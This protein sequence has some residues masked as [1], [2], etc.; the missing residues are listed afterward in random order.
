MTAELEIIL[1]YHKASKHNF[2]AYA[3]GPSRLNMSIKPD[4]FFNYHGTRHFN[5]EI[6][7]DEQIKAE[8][9]PTYE[10]V[11]LP[12]KLKP[13]ELNAESISKLFFDSFAIS[14]WKKANN[15]KWP[16]RA[17]PSSGNLHPTEVYLLSG[18]VKGLLKNPSVC[19]YAP[20]PHALEL[21]TE[22]PRETWELLSL[23]FPE[24]T[25]FVGLTSIFWR[26][27]WKYGLRAFR[28]SQHDIGHAIAALTFAAAGLGWKTSLLADMGSEEVAALLGISG[29][30][31]PE[32]QEPACLLA[33]CPADETCTK[34]RI[35]SIMVSTFKNLSWAGIPNSLSPEHVE[36]LGIE[37][38]ASA[39]QKRESDYFEKREESEKEI[40]SGTRAVSLLKASNSR[41]QL[42]PE[43]VPLRSI[44]R[45]RRS[46]IEMDNS[47]YMEKETFYA[48]L[49]RTLPE[50]NPIFNTLAFGSFTHLLLFVNRV[51]DLL[52][53]LYIFLRK[54]E[55]KE[56]FKA[57]IRPDFLWE[58]PK[59]CPSD[60]EF[61]LLLE[62]TLH[63][64]AAQL[65]CAQRKV[66]DACFTAC[67]LSEFEEPLN[68]FGAWIYPYLFW[69]CG[70]LGQL[71]YLEAEANGLRGC[72]IGC[73]F[74]DPLH[75]TIGLKGL[76]YQDLYHFA[77]G[78]PLQ[79]IGVITLPAYEK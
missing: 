65:S 73:F 38:A 60:L 42:D 72:G 31:G 69:E 66:A 18:P 9:F 17:N 10:Q 44:I 52:P 32:K 76:E 20:L 30:I 16:L 51:K 11:F 29:E 35:S 71:L 57:A 34:S 2:K 68:R 7:S 6:W 79:E 26:V 54:P 63:S 58:K 8:I 19:H 3:P 50:N 43:A 23:G 45:G 64:F 27:S 12:E 77:V 53:G 56:K 1:D 36:W 70:I 49:Q 25:F 14:A 48:M 15:T 40:K 59:N 39:A 28:Y 41:N 21:R 5:L 13:S 74:D 55:E 62:E 24:G 67:M 4:P 22:F 47:A 46:A 78:S 37:K 75:E 61:Y 33:I